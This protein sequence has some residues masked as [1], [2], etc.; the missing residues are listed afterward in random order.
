MIAA[1]GK[2]V[3]M[4][5]VLFVMYIQ[6]PLVKAQD[7]D[8]RIKADIQLSKFYLQTK[9]KLEPDGSFNGWGID[10]TKS[11]A[12]GVLETVQ[13]VDGKEQNRF[14]IQVTGLVQIMID[15]EEELFLVCKSG[16]L[17]QLWNNRPELKYKGRSIKNN[18]SKYSAQRE[19][20]FI[21]L[22]AD[23]ENEAIFFPF[24][25]DKMRGRAYFDDKGVPLPAIE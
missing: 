4:V 24:G 9:G 12:E 5:L 2:M 1:K 7:F 18:T 6:A 16:K 15:G 21:I 11:Y 17:V 13:M 3:T 10:L 25:F 8:A 20:V 14:S 19:S 22:A 23:G